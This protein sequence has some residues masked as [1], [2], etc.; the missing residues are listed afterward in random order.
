MDKVMI[1]VAPVASTDKSIIP[2][3][4]AEDVLHCYQA[5]AAMVHL[6]VRDAQGNLTTDM[7]LLEET[8]RLIRKDSDMIIEVSTGGV[9]NLTI[10][11]RCVPV[12]SELVEACSLNVGSTNLGKAVYCNPIDDVEYCV[13]ELLKMKKTPEVEVFEI[14]HTFTMQELMSQYNFINPVLFS[15]VLGHK[16]EAPATP[17]ALAAM[18]QMIPA[19]AL[20]GITHANRRDFSIIA[21]AVGMGAST[22]RIGFEDSNYLDA[23]T[24]VDTNAPLVEKTVRLLRAMD[25]EPMSPAEARQLFNIASK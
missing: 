22:V 20:W 15:I 10:K 2:E 6:H 13:R 1:S 19:G 3:K 7:S 23:K 24:V 4:I 9:S 21:A 14:G 11:E 18:I 17:Q 5:G 8:L 16:G 25:K 12:Y